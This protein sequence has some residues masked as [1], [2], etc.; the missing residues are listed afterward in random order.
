MCS[1]GAAEPAKGG[2]PVNLESIVEAV[3]DG[4]IPP[5]IYSDE[6]IFRLERERV[7][8]RSWMYLAHE[9]EIP[10]GLCIFCPD[11]WTPLR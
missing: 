2:V 10:L 11:L 3:N 9:S 7:F 4:M 8:G 1:N 5:A 6:E